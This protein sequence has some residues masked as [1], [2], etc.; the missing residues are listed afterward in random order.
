[1]GVG[2]ACPQQC[3]HLIGDATC[4]SQSSRLP[5]SLPCEYEPQDEKANQEFPDTPFKATNFLGST[6]SSAL[7]CS[8]PP[9]AALCRPS[10]A[11]RE[12]D[13]LS[14]W[15]Y[16]N[17]ELRE[18][19][20]MRDDGTLGRRPTYRFTSGATYTGQWEG[21]HRHG[22]GLQVWPD[23]VRFHGHW[24]RSIAQGLGQFRHSD[25]DWFIGEWNNG[26]AHGLGA[27]YHHAGRMT[28]VGRWVEDLQD[29]P[30]VEEFSGG[31]KYFGQFLKGKKEGSGVYIFSDG[32]TYCGQWR[33]NQCHG[34]GHYISK[35]GF[36][37]AGMWWEGFLH[38]LGKYSYP[39]GRTFCG[40]YV[41]D[42]RHGFGILKR[43][44]GW[45]FEGNW[46][47]DKMHGYGTMFR[48]SGEVDIQGVWTMGHR[49]IVGHE[50]HAKVEPT[51]AGSQP[52]MLVVGAQ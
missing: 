32:S 35:R 39:D 17:L 29:G 41:N 52:C 15:K 6:T 31:H 43:K 33:S 16:F 38:G 5:A 8:A 1:M 24:R 27:Y 18:L 25:N 7:C 4:C 10:R 12:D 3:V 37:F 30:A 23:G 34:Y 9:L 40:R 42:H 20:D 44:D 21:R 49:P 2:A 45:R 26:L 14:S 36:E 28:Y 47:Q 13:P 46:H 22:F 50:A 48:P 19:E 51:V 11:A